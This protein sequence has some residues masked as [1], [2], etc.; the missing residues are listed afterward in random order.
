MQCDIFYFIMYYKII[1]SYKL[2]SCLRRNGY[3]S[4]RYIILFNNSYYFSYYY[5]PN[6]PFSQSEFLEYCKPLTSIDLITW[7]IHGYVTDKDGNEW[8]IN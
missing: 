7:K 1:M 8:Y 6:N 5:E 2:I 4:A 3:S